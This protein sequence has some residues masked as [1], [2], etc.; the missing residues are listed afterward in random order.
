MVDFI[1]VPFGMN[2]SALEIF[3]IEEEELVR[4]YTYKNGNITHK[5]NALYCPR[6]SKVREKDTRNGGFK[7]KWV[8]LKD[9]Y[10]FTLEYHEDESGFHSKCSQCGHDVRAHTPEM[11]S[12]VSIIV[13]EDGDGPPLPLVH[14]TEPVYQQGFFIFDFKEYERVR[15]E[16]TKQGGNILPTAE[17]DGTRFVITWNNYLTKMRAIPNVS[18]VGIPKTYF[19]SL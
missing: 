14:L 6:C 18:V 16:G 12:Y 17:I 13:R 4:E 5:S 3:E 8:V 7:D 1:T 15:S 10:N 19:T 9:D 11:D 2:S